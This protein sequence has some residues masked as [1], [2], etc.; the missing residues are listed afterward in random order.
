MKSVLIIEDYDSI[1]GV[2]AEAFKWAGY[3]VETADSGDE[4]LKKAAQHE[5]DVVILDML[6]LELS[7]LDFLREFDATKHPNTLI[8]V[9]SN[10]NSPSIIEKA[11]ALGARKYL[12]KSDHTPKE[13]VEIVETLKR[14]SEH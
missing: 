5:F 6:M 1:K 3:A 11:T 14:S 9:T 8:V 4:G 12:I 10:L 7:G 13:I 2:Y